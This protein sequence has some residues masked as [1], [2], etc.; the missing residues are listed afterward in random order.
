MTATASRTHLQHR[1]RQILGSDFRFIRAR[2]FSRLTLDELQKEAP[3]ELFQHSPDG[4]QHPQ[5]LGQLLTPAG[6]RHLFRTLNFLR[7][8]ADQLRAELNPQRPGK[9]RLEQIEQLLQKADDAR[10][11]IVKANLRLV[12]ALAHKAAAAPQDYEE[13]LSE[14]HLILVNAVDKFDFSRGFRFSTYATHAVQRHFFR[15]MQRKQRR[16]QREVLS[17]PELLNHA[18]TETPEPEPLNPKVAHELIRR[19][20]DCLNP[21]ERAIIEERF[22]LS[23]K[24]SATLKMIAERVGLSKERVRQLQLSA[25]EKLQDLA[26]QMRLNP[27]T[28]A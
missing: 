23:G 17:P 16:K 18:R 20:D 19:F 22:G 28:A 21:R 6:E 27:E 26:I 11:M 7:F 2:E 25:I 5:S 9:R 14:G 8:K 1:A 12:A 13:Y 3:A 4:E 24:T 15:V 10:Q